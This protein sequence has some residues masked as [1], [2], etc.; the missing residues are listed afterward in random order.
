MDKPWIVEQL[1]TLPIRYGLTIK[2]ERAWLKCPFH[3]RN[4][5]LERT[6]S[7]V[8][9]L[10]SSLRFKL[11]SFR[12][13]ACGESGDWNKLARCLSLKT[14]TE[15]E[16]SLSIG[17]LTSEDKKLLFDVEDQQVEINSVPWDENT[18]WRGI[19]GKLISKIGGQLSYNQYRDDTEL[20][21]PVN[22]N[23]L[24]VGGIHCLIERK[25][26][27]QQGY[28]NT[29]GNW[30]QEALFPFDYVC[31]K[32]K[33]TNI[34]FLC[35][36]PRDSLNLLQYKLPALSILGSQ[37]WSEYKQNII[38]SSFDLDKIILA[39]DPDTAGEKAYTKVKKSFKQ[40]TKVIKLKMKEG[41]DPAD[42]TKYQANNIKK[43]L[44]I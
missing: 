10:E 4:G 24:M 25:S 23:G 14:I 9:N 32:Y 5:V 29:K 2:G 22:M 26:K 15:E 41:T 39:F 20:F 28:I 40:Q 36:G 43:S 19:S 30:A 35:E 13:F 31:K 44:G 1:S 34:L 16:E 17:G 38:L 12:C 8:V 21:L 37:N 18:N 42:I 7:L 27:K 11:G 6:P 33:N 3:S